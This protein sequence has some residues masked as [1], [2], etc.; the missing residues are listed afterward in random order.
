MTVHAKNHPTLMY[1]F[2]S[3]LLDALPA[4]DHGKGYHRHHHQA[5]HLTSR[6]ALQGEEEEDVSRFLLFYIFGWI[7]G[8]AFFTGEVVLPQTNV[9]VFLLC[10]LSFL[11]LSLV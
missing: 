2:P 7:C 3:N 8:F 11:N 6:T 9:L 10:L 4:D 5:R 1:F